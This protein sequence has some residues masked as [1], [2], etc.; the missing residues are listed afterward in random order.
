M[1]N[2]RSLDTVHPG[3]VRALF[4]LSPATLAELLEAVLPVLV[5]R[6]RQ[7]QASRSNRRRAVGGRR[8]RRF[9]PHQKGLVSLFYFRH[10]VAHAG[11][12]EMFGVSAGTYGKTFF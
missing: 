7:A 10:H 1:I 11:G 5:N 2:L 4:G 12:G 8:N 3:K 6:R 9:K